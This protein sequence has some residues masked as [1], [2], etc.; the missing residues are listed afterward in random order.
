MALSETK[1]ALFLALLRYPQFNIS[2]INNKKENFNF[3]LRKQSDT[4]DVS[5]LRTLHKI[6]MNI[7]PLF[8]NSK[9]Q[10]FKFQNLLEHS[11]NK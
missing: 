5:R 9:F 10:L 4:L 8:L 2:T 1:C 6:L 3:G 7:S 11:K